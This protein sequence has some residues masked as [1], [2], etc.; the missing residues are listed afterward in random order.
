MNTLLEFAEGDA[1]VDADM[2][3]CFHIDI[4]LF[5]FETSINGY[6]CKCNVA[7]INTTSGFR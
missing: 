5:I 4:S 2:G 7:S 1:D 3:F 6:C